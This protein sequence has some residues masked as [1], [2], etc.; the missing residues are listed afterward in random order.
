[1][2]SISDF[3]F[4]LI[5]DLGSDNIKVGIS[6]ETEPKLIFKNIIGVN[7]FKNEDRKFIGEECNN[8]NILKIRN[9]VEN[10]IFLNINDIVPLFNFIYK[11]LSIPENEI[12]EH[13]ILISEPILNIKKNREKISSILFDNLNIPALS[14]C[15]QPILS[16]FSTSLTSG[17]ILESGEGITQSCIIQNG[18]PIK[19][20]FVRCDYG[21]REVTYYLKDIFKNSGYSFLT[22]S[23]ILM[24]KNIKEQIC[25]IN[26]DNKFPNES[27]F[28]LPDGSNIKI[29]EEKIL[30]SEL[31]FNPS[32]N[33]LKYLSFQ[34]MIIKSVNNFDIQL[35]RNMYENII[36][37]GGNTLFKGIQERLNKEIKKLAPKHTKIKILSSPKRINSCVIGGNII[38]KMSSFNNMWILKEEFLDKGFSIIYDKGI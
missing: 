23:D 10:G 3:K 11:K 20:T 6:G 37:F 19:N 5:I 30:S 24:I 18:I 4:P 29:A 22:F 27:E 8:I 16:I 7:K 26:V 28:K 2:S 12:R 34:E 36:I 17:I 1:M 25:Y 9:I 33:N 13:P 32:L 14:F 35:R 21:G 15:S 31:L 38:S